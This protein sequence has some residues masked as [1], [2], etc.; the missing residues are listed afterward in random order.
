[1]INTLK[2]IA[3]SIPPLRKAAQTIRARR[4][5][6]E[7]KRLAEKERRLFKELQEKQSLI[8]EGAQEAFD[9]LPLHIEWEITEFCNTR[10]SYCFQA[11]G[12]HKNHYCSLEQAKTAIEHFASAN[13]SSYQFLILGGEPLTHP[14]VVEIIQLLDERLGNRIEN[15]RFLTNGS[16]REGQLDALIEAARH[17]TLLVS[18]TVHFESVDTEKLFNLV[19]QCARKTNLEFGIMLHP[20]LFDAVKET[21]ERFIELRK[22]HPFFLSVNLLREPLLFTGLDSRYLPEHF[23]WAKEA[24]AR[25]DEAASKGPKTSYDRGE[26]IGRKNFVVERCAGGASEQIICQ[27]LTEL[28]RE[29]DGGFGGMYCCAGTFVMDVHPSGKARGAVC[30]LAP[31]ICNIFEENPFEQDNLMQTVSC[32]RTWCADVKNWRIAKFLSKDDAEAYLEECRKKQ[33][34]LL[35]SPREQ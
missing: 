15:L 7:R 17:F 30:R 27:G 13:R 2:Q 28:E 31:F 1:M 14:N 19:E 34:M 22:H 32:T 16:F 8:R 3:K 4:E 24:Q 20:E 25:F 6:A 29:T 21:T 35:E 5:E 9:S 33:R 10:C 12:G 26:E 18:I 23:E 11:I